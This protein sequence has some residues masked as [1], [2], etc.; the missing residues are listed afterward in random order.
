MAQVLTSLGR[1]CAAVAFLPFPLHAVG[2]PMPPHAADANS[3]FLRLPMIFEANRG[4]AGPEVKSIAKGH[5][6]VLLFKRGE[7]D[8][9]E[10]GRSN[11]IDHVLRMKFLGSNA[12]VGIEGERVL[13]GESN[14]FNGSDPRR[15]LT[16][17]PTYG[18]LRYRNIYP[19]IDLI[20]RGENRQLEYDLVLEPGADP[21][22][23]QLYFENGPRPTIDARGDLLLR[24]RSGVIRQHR[25][26]AYQHLGTVRQSVPCQAVLRGR[27]TVGFKAGPYDSQKPLTID[28]IL[29]YSTYLGGSGNDAAAGV[30]T[31]PAG[32]VYLLVNSSGLT[33]PPSGGPP[34][35]GAFVIKLDDS[36]NV[37]YSTFIGPATAAGIARNA[38]EIF[39]T[40]SAFSNFPT[41][42][43]IRNFVGGSGCGPKGNDTCPDAFVAKLSYTGSSLLYSTF[44]GGTGNDEGHS[45]AV[46]AYGNAYVTG[47]TAAGD[48]PTTAGSFQGTLPGV[49]SAFVSKINVDGSAL[50]YSTYLGGNITSSGNSIT[51]DYQG[52]A[53][54]AGHTQSQTFPTTR[55]AFQT[56]PSGFV[57]AFVAKLN[58]AGSAL[59]YSTYLG[60][61]DA[62]FALAVAVDA[63]GNAYVAGNTRSANF[64]TASAL[65][66]ACGS[67]PGTGDAFVAKLDPVG[68]RLVYS[69]YLGGSGS[70]GAS[71][72]A[73]DESGNVFLTGSTGSPNFPTIR[74]LFDIHPGSH[75]G[76]AFVSWIN[77]SGTAL[78]F[79]TLVGGGFDT[80][81]AISLSGQTDLYVAGSTSTQYFPV[82]NPV[83]STYGGGG[84]DAF[85]TRVTLRELSNHSPVPAA[86]SDGWPIKRYVFNDAGT[87]VF[88]GG[89]YQGQ[90]DGIVLSSATQFKKFAA[91]GDPVPGLPGNLFAGF[92]M[93]DFGDLALNNEDDVAFS[94]DIVAC[95]S[96]AALSSCL[97]SNPRVSGLFLY[98]GGKISKVA[99]EGD[100]VPGRAGIKM[101]GFPRLQLNDTGDIAFACS[102][103]TAGGSFSLWYYA[104]DR[105]GGKH[106][107]DTLL[108]PAI[109]E[110]GTVVFASPMKGS[111]SAGGLFVYDGSGIHKIVVSGDPI[112]GFPYRQFQFAS[113]SG[114][115]PFM[116]IQYVLNNPGDVA[117]NPGYAGLILSLG[118][119]II[120]LELRGD[121]TSQINGNFYALDDVSSLQLNNSGRAA[122]QSEI[123]CGRD[124]RGIFLSPAQL[125]HV[126]NGDFEAAGE[127]NRSG[128]V[129]RGM[130]QSV[131]G[132]LAAE[133]VRRVVPERERAAC[134]R[135]VSVADDAG[136]S[137]ILAQQKEALLIGLVAER[138]TKCRLAVRI[139]GRLLEIAEV[140]AAGRGVART[141]QLSQSAIPVLECPAHIQK[142]ETDGAVV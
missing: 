103:S 114:E 116:D 98:S 5:G 132:V 29:T 92:P 82:Q 130:Q 74:P 22:N 46:D 61:N 23:V 124:V 68:S 122:F 67:C 34:Q 117:F 2:N 20:F 21:R 52:S 131:G 28:P 125:A 96:A 141:D 113:Y 32:N 59:T 43:P 12:S 127:D 35:S 81:T 104:T 66:P 100:P 119:K 75:A 58:P 4:Q 42:N 62:D 37:V 111:S 108:H 134:R 6:Y 91:L 55:G 94:A 39:V 112:P 126:P 120:P 123:C 65:Q 30:L 142:E 128:I 115:Q 90:A 47:S 106:P 17:I 110:S 53:Y 101:H 27:R 36:R 41:V 137:P 25:P 31:D 121:L 129:Y 77:P 7:I 50:V 87:V 69:T 57:D 10:H 93:R 56:T 102:T 135:R 86:L 44:L 45:I 139:D 79:S 76:Y 38:G 136:D 83:Q 3:A 99:L 54:V 11:N 19:G 49:G 88:A 85:L 15:W 109:N 33:F 73:I 64:P 16:K 97:N 140:P 40:G 14:Y 133:S 8:I 72:I 89:D 51:V 80:G 78:L 95:P 18:Q 9:A 118:G 107:S 26:S 70:D 48:F 1:W 84:S 105:F 71:A 138:R 63:I 13:P 24:T 60:G